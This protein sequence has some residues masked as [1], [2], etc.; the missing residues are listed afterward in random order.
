M[1]KDFPAGDPALEEEHLR[2]RKVEDEI[3]KINKKVKEYEHVLHAKSGGQCG[4]LLPDK[5][6]HEYKS[7]K[8]GVFM[9]G[10]ALGRGDTLGKSVDYN[11]L[12]DMFLEEH[13]R[14]L[15]TDSEYHS[16]FEK[17]DIK[18]KV[19]NHDLFER[20]K[21]EAGV[22]LPPEVYSFARKK[23]REFE[24][25]RREQIRDRGF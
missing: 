5:V 21:G 11:Q 20:S 1:L 14:F 12:S 10:E 18:I 6:Y 16:E 4:T 25:K 9:K 3:Q 8:L 24:E 23:V 2:L 13:K 22:S 17:I 19:Y 15:L 7:L